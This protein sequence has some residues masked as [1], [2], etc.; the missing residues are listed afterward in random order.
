M[1]NLLEEKKERFF[2]P[3]S[4]IVSG[5]RTGILGRRI[6]PDGEQNAKSI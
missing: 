2:N 3:K 4:L 6:L 5:T 1:A